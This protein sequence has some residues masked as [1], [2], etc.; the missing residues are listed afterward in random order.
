[1]KDFLFDGHKLLW[2]LDRLAA[3]QNGEI[4]PPIY[5]EISPVSY[6]NHKCVFCGLDFAQAESHL[7]RADVMV[8][9]LREMGQ[10]GIRSV[11]FAG[12]GEPLLHPELATMVK[13]ARDSGI[14]VSLTTNGSTGS[15][16]TWQNL[17]PNLTWIRF[18]IDAATPNVYAS[19]HGV[20]ENSFD[21]TL[22]SLQAALLV[23]QQMGLDV[24]IGVQY[25][26]VSENIDEVEEAIELFSRLGADYLCF[27]PYS[28]HPQM[29]NKNGFTYSTEI[30]N[31]IDTIVTRHIG[32]CKTL[33]SF[34]KEATGI[35]AAGPGRITHCYALPFWG[36]I[37]SQGDFHTC[38]VYLNDERFNVGNLY[39]TSM[40]A[41][42]EGE[43]RRASIAYA[44]RELS[45]G[46]ECRVNCRMA[47]INEFLHHLKNKPDHI[48][49]I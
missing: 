25:L 3:W 36:Y 15:P 28:E 29:I 47:R 4:V 32:T 13:T 46:H 2:H 31:K 7:L 22:E 16:E 30:I 43:M 38:S 21:R 5:I 40:Q 18:S 37:S 11:M 8:K 1:M 48:N 39:Q 45:A 41:I 35:Y 42:F 6:C 9:R 44:E 24:T 12:E 23:K 19:V 17:L 34:R 20:T 14:D 33:L 10:A 27:K 26:L 49:F